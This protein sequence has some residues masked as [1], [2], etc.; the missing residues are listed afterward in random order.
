MPTVK[1]RNHDGGDDPRAKIPR[2]D[3][4]CLHV[5]T[6]CFKTATVV[7]QRRAQYNYLGDPSFASISY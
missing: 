7:Y 5:A 2:I 6:Y 4:K 3:G 1:K